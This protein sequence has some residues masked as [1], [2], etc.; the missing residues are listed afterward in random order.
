MLIFAHFVKLAKIFR[1]VQF[2]ARGHDFIILTS[3]LD[4]RLV[5]SIL[6]DMGFDEVEHKEAKTNRRHTA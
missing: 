3:I 5:L 1:D 4:G 6:F 2:D